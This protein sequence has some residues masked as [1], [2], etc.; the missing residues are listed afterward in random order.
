MSTRRAWPWFA[1]AALHAVLALAVLWAQWWQPQRETPRALSV[2]LWEGA[3]APA[4][5][6]AAADVEPVAPVEAP[7]PAPEPAPAPPPTPPAEVN[8]GRKPPKEA[9]PRA[10]MRA[11]APK[12]ERPPRVEARPEPRPEPKPQPKPEAKPK[13]EAKTGARP[14]PD[15]AATAAKPAA[16]ASQ[17]ADDLLAELGQGSR[18]AGRDRATQAGA[19]GQGAEGGAANGSANL[20]AYQN[21]VVQKLRPLVEVPDDLTGNPSVELRVALLPSLEVRSVQLVRSS[22]HAGYDAA[23]QRAVREART[24]PSLMDGM[25]FDDVRTVRLVFRPR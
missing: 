15:K 19:K 6:S 4:A 24:F 10:D 20:A 16:R 2:E 21:R 1:S 12:P 13:V 23:V 8:L 17:E 3:A 25:T 9:P 11:E 7:P 22:G 18:G 14:A 5:Q